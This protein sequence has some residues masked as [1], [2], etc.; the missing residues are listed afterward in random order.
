MSQHLYNLH[1][2]PHE[3]KGQ[4]KPSLRRSIDLRFDVADKSA[5]KHIDGLRISLVGKSPGRSHMSSVVA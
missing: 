5:D 2:Y 4:R 3:D 1:V